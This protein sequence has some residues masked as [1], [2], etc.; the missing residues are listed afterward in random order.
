MRY[1]SPAQIAASS[2]PAPPL[3]STITFLSSLGSR[4]TIASRISSS[5][6][7]IRARA[8][9]ELGARLGVL[10]AL[11]EQLLRPF[12]VRLR[13]APG[14]SQLGGGRQAVVDAA[15][16][17]EPLA[18]PDHVGIAHLRLGLAEPRFDLLDQGF[19]HND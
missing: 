10:A 14:L 12:G 11:F 2:P 6:V 3:I 8:T 9:L 13:Q 17:G 5:S 7:S 4:S 16:L 15:D 1:R 18:I 19:D